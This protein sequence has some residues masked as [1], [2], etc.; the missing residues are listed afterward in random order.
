MNK[1][2]QK[3]L[4][5]LQFSVQLQM[6][7]PWHS[8]DLDDCHRY[9]QLQPAK[10]VKATGPQRLIFQTTKRKERF[11]INLGCPLIYQMQI[12]ADAIM[13]IQTG[14][15]Q[16]ISICTELWGRSKV[17]LL[18]SVDT[19]LGLRCISPLQVYLK[20]KFIFR[21]VILLKLTSSHPFS[22]AELYRLHSCTIISL[23]H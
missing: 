13:S 12:R 21:D 8:F 14:N 7:E 20:D 22:L 10:A 17:S 6:P 16:K 1:L 5:I 23:A 19:I 15:F 3:I 4:S 18:Y 11:L 9:A 2:K